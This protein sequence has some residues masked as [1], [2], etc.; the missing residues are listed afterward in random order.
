MSWTE[1][2]MREACLEVRRIKGIRR[3]ARKFNI[4]YP[5]LRGRLSGRLP[6]AVAHQDQQRLSMV[7]E[8][9][10]ADWILFQ[11]SL[12]NGPTHT[13]IKDLAQRITIERGD[14]LKIGNRWIRQFLNRHP[15]LKTQKPRRVDSARL[16]CAIDEV[17]RPWFDYLRIPAVQKIPSQFRYNIDEAGLAKG[18]GSNGYVVGCAKRRAMTQKKPDSRT[19]I[20]FMECISATGEFLQPLVI[21]KGASVQ[22]QWFPKEIG[23]YKG[24]YFTATK[25]G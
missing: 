6:H 19:W 13:Q 18:I 14:G 3:A 10:L 4:P 5:T 21:Y 20:T 11:A 24:W 9:E 1:A 25:K 2:D 8:D 15:V 7:Q 23:A 16:K 22:Q 12:G 17:I